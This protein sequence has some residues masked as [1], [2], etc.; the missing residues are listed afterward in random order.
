MAKRLHNEGTY[1][2]RTING[3]DYFVHQFHYT[4]EQGLRKR[5]AVYSTLQDELAAKKST[6]LAKQEKLNNPEELLPGDDMTI[7]QFIDTEWF[8]FLDDQV[9]TGEYKRRSVVNYKSVTDNHIKPVFGHFKINKITSKDILNGYRA[10]KKELVE[11]PSGAMVRKVSDT[12]IHDIQRRFSVIFQY[13]IEQEYVTDNPTIGVRNNRVLRNES[14]KEM[15]VLTPKQFHRVLEFLQEPFVE[16]KTGYN[17]SNPWIHY[18]P[19]VHTLLHTGARRNE[20]LGL[21]WKDVD[22]TLATATVRQQV[23]VLPGGKVEFTAVKTESSYREILLTYENTQVLQ[24]YFDAQSYP[25]LNSNGQIIE[26][27]TITPRPED[28]IFRRL[29]G[30]Y[31]EPGKF[32]Q[33]NTLT[34]AWIKIM[35]IL[36]YD[37]R[38]HDIRHTHASVLYENGADDLEV[39]R[40][41]GHSNVGITQNIYT[42]LSANKKRETANIVGDA[43]RKL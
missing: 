20:I 4:N 34:Q 42:H 27:K 7:A 23:D 8:P 33:P 29:D 22:L 39:S 21:R 10:M 37:A 14:K 30:A 17:L 1:F 9:I 43:L 2:K 35:N 41:L 19:V 25:A 18:Y 32:I 31:G 13:A 26:G 12:T 5:K 40:R 3:K 38:L 6:F 16:G 28:L 36:G 15:K 11:D 24:E